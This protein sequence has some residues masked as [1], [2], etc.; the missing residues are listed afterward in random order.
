MAE[1]DPALG[2]T[3]RCDG[4]FGVGCVWSVAMWVLGVSL[5]CVG[6][7]CVVW[8]CGLVCVCVRA[9]CILE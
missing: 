4:V 1:N 6:R 8:G 7:V 2:D 3:C 9:K 5:A